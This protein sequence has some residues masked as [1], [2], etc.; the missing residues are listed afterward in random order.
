MS[1]YTDWLASLKPGDE[2]ALR[3]RDVRPS[4]ATVKKTTMNN[5]I[6]SNGREYCRHYGNVRDWCT[7]DVAQKIEPINRRE[8]M[9]SVLSQIE[10]ERLSTGALQQVL[11]LI[12]EI[13][14]HEQQGS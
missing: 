6:L 5:I 7:P 4:A 10:W 1:E 8:H 13:R 12:E 2:V 3:Y 14:K 9:V 11:V